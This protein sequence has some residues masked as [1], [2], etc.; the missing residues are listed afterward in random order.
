MRFVADG[1]RREATWLPRHGL[2]ERTRTAL[3]VD[4]MDSGFLV[5]ASKDLG[6]LGHTL[7]FRKAGKW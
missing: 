3:R 7:L 4:G 6:I 5:C 2:G 1:S